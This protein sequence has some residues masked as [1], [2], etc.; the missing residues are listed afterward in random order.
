[1]LNK[2]RE[3]KMIKALVNVKSDGV[4]SIQGN[5]VKCIFC[6]FVIDA[7]YSWGQLTD[8]EQL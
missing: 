3:R 5:P 7:F 1:M 8:Q 6:P 2:E 4:H